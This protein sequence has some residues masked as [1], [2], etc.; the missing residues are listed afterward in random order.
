MM[1]KLDFNSKRLAPT[2]DEKK[3]PVADPNNY[4]GKNLRLLKVII[5]SLNKMDEKGSNLETK[6]GILHKSYK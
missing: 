6:V 5:H 1:M 2:K 4:Y 3:D